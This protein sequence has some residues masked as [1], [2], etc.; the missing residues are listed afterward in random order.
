MIASAFLFQAEVLVDLTV[1]LLIFPT[2]LSVAA[3]FF[4]KEERLLG[5]SLLAVVGMFGGCLAFYFAGA[6]FFKSLLALFA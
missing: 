6:D 3:L 2:I 1:L 4:H 5:R